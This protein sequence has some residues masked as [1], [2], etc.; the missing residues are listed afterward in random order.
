MPIPRPLVVL[1]M[2]RVVSP[3]M[4]KSSSSST[5]SAGFFRPALRATAAASIAFPPAVFVLSGLLVPGPAEL[6]AA[7]SEP[8]AEA[9]R[10]VDLGRCHGPRSELRFGWLKPGE[11]P[12]QPAAHSSVCVAVYRVSVD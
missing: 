2:S 4:H 3:G 8:L 5:S 11:E 9:V 6:P 7:D 1:T 12:A 10:A